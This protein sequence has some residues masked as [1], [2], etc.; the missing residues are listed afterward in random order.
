MLFITACNKTDVSSP[1][2]KLS[3]TVT[4]TGGAFSGV[5]IKL[6]GSAVGSTTTDSNGNYNF[7]GL[8]NGTYIVT[9]SLN[10]YI[11]NP[12]STAI[13]IS[14][15]NAS[16]TNFVATA[17][18]ASK[19]VINGT[20]TGDVLSGVKIRLSGDATGTTLTDAN[21]KYNF[22]NIVDG[23]YTLTPS[24]TGGYTFTPSNATVTAAG[25]DVTVT[26]FIETAVPTT[27]YS[28]SGTVNLS[29][30]GYSDVAISLTGSA[31]GST[32]TDSS[33]NF[34]IA[35]LYN[36][37]YTVTAVPTKDYSFTPSST[38]VVINNSSVSSTN[39]TAVSNSSSFYN[40]SGT[41][42]GATL[43]GVT[44]TL[45]GSGSATTITN[46]SGNYSFPYIVNGSYTVTPSLSGHSFSPTNASVTVSDADVTVTNFE[47]D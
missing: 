25:A 16:N 3:G 4:L 39:F 41:V 18:T 9:P 5:T 26:N 22:P 33:G 10:N 34:T 21:G 20:V 2:Y 31:T 7:T 32:T 14:G 23:N 46:E 12:V 6:A 17:N 42:T 43:S 35:G 8:A 38:A 29:G 1:T 37:N 40:I 28:I 27:T 47:E 30:S 13:V 11:F 15:A 36:G 19:Y 45:S 24:L 44:I